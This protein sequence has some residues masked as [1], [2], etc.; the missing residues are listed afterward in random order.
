M[1][2]AATDPVN[3]I[4]QPSDLSGVGE[5]RLAASAVSP[6]L[7]VLCVGMT[8]KELAPLVYTTWPHANL[9]DAE[10]PGEKTGGLNWLDDVP[11]SS[12]SEWVNGT[13]LNATVVD[14]IFRWGKG[15]QRRPPVFQRVSIFLTISM[16]HANQIRVGSFRQNTM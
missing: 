15:Y 13:V 2:D 11:S 3:E 7:N 8:E 5:Y 1:Y 14:D 16:D 4:L 6:A 10:L 12:E 9:T